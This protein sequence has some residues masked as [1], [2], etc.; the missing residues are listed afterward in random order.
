MPFFFL[1]YISP[2]QGP[3]ELFKFRQYTLAGLVH[4]LFVDSLHE[5]VLQQLVAGIPFPRVG[6]EHFFNEVSLSLSE[7]V[8]RLEL[9]QKLVVSSLQIP[10]EHQGFVQLAHVYS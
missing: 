9:F 2:E 8:L 5:F 6:P 1:C 3:V 7:F 4:C 10:D